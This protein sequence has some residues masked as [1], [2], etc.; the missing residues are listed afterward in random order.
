MPEMELMR[1]ARREGKRIYYSVAAPKVLAVL[2]T[3]YG[4]YCPKADKAPTAS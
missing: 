4:L 1:S 3:Q 2:G